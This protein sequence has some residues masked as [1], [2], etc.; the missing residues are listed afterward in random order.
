MGYQED[1]RNHEIA[2]DTHDAH[3]SLFD[4]IYENGNA[5]LLPDEAWAWSRTILAVSGV[6]ALA[7]AIG[8]L[9]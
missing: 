2:M 9:S 8:A 4:A 7:A 6:A 3:E 5:K 1:L